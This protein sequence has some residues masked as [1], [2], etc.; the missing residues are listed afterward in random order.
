MTD[1]SAVICVIVLWRSNLA[2]AWF[3]EVPTSNLDEGTEYLGWVFR[4]FPHFFQEYPVIPYIRSW[5]LLLFFCQLHF[6]PGTYHLA[7]CS[8]KCWQ[9]FE[10]TPNE[11][12]IV[13]NTTT[14]VL[15]S[16]GPNETCCHRLYRRSV[17]EVKDVTLWLKFIVS[18]SFVYNSWFGVQIGL[19]IF[20]Y[21]SSPLYG[22]LYPR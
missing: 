1:L 3:L 7:R 15:S 11:Q 4:G 22:T 19:L 2:H 13:D 9:H 8:Q 5:L 18:V 20:D 16:T 6:T 14:I 17:Y 12:N 21:V 10:I